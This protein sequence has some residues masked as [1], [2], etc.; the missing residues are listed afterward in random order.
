MKPL[1]MLGFGPWV[2]AA[3]LHAQPEP[4]RATDLYRIQVPGSPTWN[5][6]GSRLAYTVRTTTE[7]GSDT[8]IWMY[9]AGAHRKLTGGSASASSPTWHPDGGSLYFLRSQDRRSTLF[10][11]P[12]DGGEALPAFTFTGNVGGYELSPDG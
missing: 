4:V 12:L 7:T 5:P 8:Q 9:A 3:S 1:L 6:D 11:L 2:G 10:R